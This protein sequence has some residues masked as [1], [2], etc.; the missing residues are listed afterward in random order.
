MFIIDIITKID[1]IITISII[2]GNDFKRNLEDIVTSPSTITSGNS[3]CENTWR[4][5]NCPGYHELFC[6]CDL[7]VECPE[8]MNCA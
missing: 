5:E 1:I 7:Y 3:E 4:A 2:V 8:C 6:P